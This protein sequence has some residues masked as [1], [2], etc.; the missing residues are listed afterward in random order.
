MNFALLGIIWSKCSKLAGSS[1]PC[2][3]SG[4][5]FFLSCFSTNPRT[6]SSPAWLKLRCKKSGKR[7]CDGGM[8][9]CPLSSVTPGSVRFF[10]VTYAPWPHPLPACAGLER[11]FWGLKSHCCY[12]PD[13]NVFWPCKFLKNLVGFRH[14]CLLTPPC[15]DNQT[16]KILSR[17]S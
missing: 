2:S 3:H 16:P 10:L 13:L 15:A 8:V 12:R 5:L 17:Q 1:V 4:A 14:I 9:L 6:L 11:L 7:E